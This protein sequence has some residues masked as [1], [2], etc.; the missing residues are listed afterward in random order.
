MLRYIRHSSNITVEYINKGS[1]NGDNTYSTRNHPKNNTN[2][3]AR[4]R[5]TA[6]EYTI[7]RLLVDNCK[8][9]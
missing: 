6:K 9:L 8:S 7:N 4:N 2:T 1:D 3:I 5:N